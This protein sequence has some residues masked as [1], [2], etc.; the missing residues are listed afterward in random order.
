M[1]YKKNDTRINRTGRPKGS[2]NKTNSEVKAIVKQLVNDNL[3]QVQADLDSLEPKDRLDIM[4]KLMGFVLPKAT[5]TD[6]N[7]TNLQQP[8]II[9]NSEET[10]KQIEMLK[11]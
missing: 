8:Q 1:P 2:P 3:P 4:V 9:V 11:R 10:K 6:V 5:Q 7:F